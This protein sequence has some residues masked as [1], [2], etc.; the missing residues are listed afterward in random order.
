MPV[1][2]RLVMGV[3]ACMAL[4]FVCAGIY[5]TGYNH[6][7][8]KCLTEWQQETERRRLQDIDIL[9]E[10]YRQQRELQ[11]R[12]DTLREEYANEKDT[13]NRRHDDLIAGLL[14]RPEGRAP[15]GVPAG[16][17]NQDG[18]TGAGL[19]R[20]DAGFL[21][22]YAADAAKV[23]AALNTCRTAY[24]ALHDQAEKAIHR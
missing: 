13:I 19:A 21:A 9:A 8:T 17:G 23:A 22:G 15:T 18:C 14:N 4:A 2:N 12:I 24:E 5:R 3:G 11:A 1:L 10:A 7:R 20:P 16:P 6:G